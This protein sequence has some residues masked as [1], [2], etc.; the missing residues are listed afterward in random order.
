MNPGKFLE[1]S[2]IS[3][4][5]KLNKKQST[6]DHGENHAILALMW[7]VLKAITVFHILRLVM[8][9]LLMA[10]RVMPF[11]KKAEDIYAD[12]KIREAQAKEVAKEVAS[13][14]KSIK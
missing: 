12:E 2:F 1:S 14:V 13:N 8:S 3:S 10:I 11:P 7:L 5:I 4:Q 6:W 9:Y